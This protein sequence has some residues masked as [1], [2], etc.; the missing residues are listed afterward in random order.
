MNNNIGVYRSFQEWY[1]KST[2]LEQKMDFIASQ[3]DVNYGQYLTMKYISDDGCN[4]PTLLADVF[5][6][7][8]PAISRKLNAL[9][10]KRKIVK[11]HNDPSD[12]RKVRL[13]LTT[14]GKSDLVKMDAAYQAWFAEEV[15]NNADINVGLLKQQMDLIIDRIPNN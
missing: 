6:V 8:R 9:Y 10:E 3:Y 14:S 13:V 5:G 4:E 7:S 1:L 2:K 12:Q 15:L 11:K